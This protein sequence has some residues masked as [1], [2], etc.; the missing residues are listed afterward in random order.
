MPTALRE[1]PKRP[2]PEAGIFRD[3]RVFSERTLAASGVSEKGLAAANGMFGAL[4]R[5]SGK[6]GAT[7]APSGAIQERLRAVNFTDL[8]KLLRGVS[9]EHVRLLSTSA[10]PSGFCTMLGFAQKELAEAVTRQS[11]APVGVREMP[12]KLKWPDSVRERYPKPFVPDTRTG[13]NK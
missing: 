8:G 2:A 10:R 5:A 9:T 11:H 1:P 7:Y 6:H 13:T 3:A 4:I 12:P